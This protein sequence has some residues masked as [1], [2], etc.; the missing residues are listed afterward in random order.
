M[1]TTSDIVREA[2]IREQS[3]RG[4]WATFLNCASTA[5]QTAAESNDPKYRAMRLRDARFYVCQSRCY[6]NPRLP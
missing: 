6:P 2:R 4:F 5:I 1:L 3:N